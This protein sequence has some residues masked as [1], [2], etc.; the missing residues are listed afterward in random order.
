MEQSTLSFKKLAQRMDQFDTDRKRKNIHPEDLAKSIIL[1]GAELLEHFQ[2]DT[3]L[4]NRGDKIAE[5][6]KE[7]VEREVADILIYLMKF[8][9]EMKIDIV[10][11]TLKKIERLEKKYPID[12]RKN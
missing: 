8:C 11:A 12:Y 2:R 4:R 3:T 5:K 10:A 1:E 9:R 6:D 7:E